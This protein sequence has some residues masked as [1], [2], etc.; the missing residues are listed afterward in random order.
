MGL[1]LSA[2]RLLLDVEPV[3]RIL[4]DRDEFELAYGGPPFHR[5]I[6]DE[7]LPPI[8]RA[9][10]AALPGLTGSDH[11]YP[12]RTFGV[13]EFVLDPDGHRRTRSWVE[14]ERTLPYRILHGDDELAEH[15][16]STT[17]FP[18][19]ASRP[20]FLRRAAEAIDAL[21]PVAAR[22]DFR[23]AELVERG[24]YKAVQWDDEDELFT[25]VTANLAGLGRYY[26]RVADDG[27][28]LVIECT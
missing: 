23:L 2:Y 8:S 21:D 26:R 1:D 3:R 14:R 4:A 22:A 15:V 10:C 5:L 12:D 7:Q 13:A 20:A 28:D 24:V 16:V 9:L 11:P 6:G 18:W 19:R 27:L 17:G 25:T